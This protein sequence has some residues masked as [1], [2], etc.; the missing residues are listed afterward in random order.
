MTSRFEELAWSATALGDI[1][2]RRRRDPSTGDEVHEVKLDDEFL[3]SSAFVVAERALAELALR[4]VH[5]QEL[6]VVVGGLGLGCTAA[7]VLEDERV[8]S[9]VV[10]EALEPVIDWHRGGLVPLGAALT[11]DARCILVHEDFFAW[12][13]RGAVP[14]PGQDRCH[15]LLVDIDHSPSH[16][17]HR[18]HATFYTREG[19][20][21][22]AERLHLGGVFALWS[23]D[24]PDSSFLGL[25]GEVFATSRAEVVSFHNPLTGGTSANTVYIATTA[26]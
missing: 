10:V 15:A 23:D 25:L 16:V 7:A 8:R 20:A 5:G 3:M 17:L 24:A 13:P 1:S 9:L 14:A 19:L 22:S 26:A 12:V 11:G 6:D 21:R 2:L 4:E 18:S